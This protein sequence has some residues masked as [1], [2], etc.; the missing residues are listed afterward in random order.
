MVIFLVV[1]VGLVVVHDHLQSADDF[2]AGDRCIGGK[3]KKKKKKRLSGV[4]SLRSQNTQ[5][6]K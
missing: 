2:V 6:V 3:K 1:L 5:E 4:F